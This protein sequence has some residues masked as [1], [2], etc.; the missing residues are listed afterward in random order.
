[1]SPIGFIVAL[2]LIRRQVSRSTFRSASD[3]I[4]SISIAR[5]V[6]RQDIL[7]SSRLESADHFTQAATCPTM[8]GSTTRVA[9]P[10]ISDGSAQVTLAD[11][12]RCDT[13]L[14]QALQSVNEPTRSLYNTF[15]RMTD[16][17][18]SPYRARPANAVASPV[19]LCLKKAL[20]RFMRLSSGAPMS[21]TS[22]R[23]RL[24][25][26]LKRSRSR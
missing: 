20:L 10:A 17:Q 3:N 18:E 11:D 16:R 7:I 15:D 14:L 26:S 4:H 21:D 19:S 23:R 24:A 6:R 5:R 22:R 25:A 1:M 12:A 9:Y 8:S 13:I 2:I